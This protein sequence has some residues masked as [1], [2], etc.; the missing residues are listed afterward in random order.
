MIGLTQERLFSEVRCEAKNRESSGEVGR[1]VQERFG[2]RLARERLDP[3]KT[4]DLTPQTPE[5]KFVLSSEVLVLMR[6]M[7]LCTSKDTRNI[8]DLNMH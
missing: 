6:S 7:S 1:E 8:T 5:S 2:E 4:V 3:R